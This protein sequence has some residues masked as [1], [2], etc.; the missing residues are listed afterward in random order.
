M[1][2]ALRQ[3][4]ILGIKT[5]THFLADVIESPAFAEGR[6]H[7]GF[8]PEHFSGW[9]L[10]D[11]STSELRIA[12]VAAAALEKTGPVVRTAAAGKAAFSP[13]KSNN[14]WRIAGIG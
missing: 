4:V 9:K 3:Y 6:T 10:P 5:T 13:W 14:R 7:T 12:L 1:A 2:S 11:A 8:I